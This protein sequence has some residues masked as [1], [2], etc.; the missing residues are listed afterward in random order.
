MDDITGDGYG[1]CGSRVTYWDTKVL[2]VNV[3]KL[4]LVYGAF[5][6]SYSSTMSQNTSVVVQRRFKAAYLCFRT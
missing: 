4:H 2:A 5:R 6:V 1:G 3:H